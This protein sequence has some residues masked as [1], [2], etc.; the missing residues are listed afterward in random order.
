M[1]MPVTGRELAKQLLSDNPRLKV[2]YTTGYS[3]EWEGLPLQVMGEAGAVL[4][5]P[6]PPQK[7]AA[8]LRKCFDGTGG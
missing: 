8:T 6:Y 5:K 7:L 3:A 2:I 1:V 4:H